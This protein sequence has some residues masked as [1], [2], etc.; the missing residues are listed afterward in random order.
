[1]PTSKGTS[2][3]NADR[4]AARSDGDPILAPPSAAAWDAWLR[5]N[6]ARSAGVRLRIPKKSAESTLTY[7]T[8]LDAALIWGWIDSQKQALDDTA[9]LQRFSPRKLR[10][11]WSKINCAK[12][13]VLIAAGRMEAPGLAE[14]DRAKRDGRWER[15]YD[16]PKTSTVPSDLSEALDQNARARAFFDTL[17]ATNRYAIL[18]RVMTAKLPETRAKRIATLVA[19]CAAHEALHPARTKATRAKPGPAQPTKRAR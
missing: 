14:V 5:A 18:H 10:S 12:A 16:S 4:T 6:H 7:A 11:P 8:A 17:D 2:T 3:P 15:A 1:M 9:W 13:E 19:M